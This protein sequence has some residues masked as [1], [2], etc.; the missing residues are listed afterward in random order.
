[1]LALIFAGCA[2]NQS[3]EPEQVLVPIAVPCQTETPTSPSLKFSPPYSDIYQ[4][5]RDLLGDREI[6][7]GYQRE[8]EA[9][10]KSCK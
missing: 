7:S 10:L 5:V 3:K 8:L 6:L 9:A 4:A 1:M 2:H